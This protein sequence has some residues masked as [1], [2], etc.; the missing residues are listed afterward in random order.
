[1]GGRHL[2]ILPLI[3]NAFKYVSHFT[4]KSNEIR[5][6]WKLKLGWFECVICNTIERALITTPAQ[7]GGIGLTNLKR[8]LELLYPDKHKLIFDVSESNYTVRLA[9]KTNEN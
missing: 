9:L 5:M 3:E 7:K 2:L 8:R 1:V 4:D 6:A